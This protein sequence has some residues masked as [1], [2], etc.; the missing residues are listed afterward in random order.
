MMLL[1]DSLLTKAE[2]AALRDAALTLN[3]GDGRATAGAHARVVK[4]NDQALPSPDLDA[5]LA[6]VETTLAAACC[7][8]RPRGPRR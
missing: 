3:F 2:V 7:F 6:K 1:I 4:A 5:V 8:A